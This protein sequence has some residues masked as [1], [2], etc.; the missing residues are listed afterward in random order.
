MNNRFKMNKRDH[1]AILDS[2]ARLLADTEN[3]YLKTKNY[4]WNSSMPTFHTFN[5]MFENQY[6]ELAS[7]FDLIAERIR[8][9]GIAAPVSHIQFNN[10]DALKE[11]SNPPKVQEMIQDLLAD[12]ETII[13]TVRSVF[14]EAINAEDEITKDLMVQR[15]QAHE[16][17]A[18]IFRDYLINK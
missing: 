17:S 15:I 12:Q 8:A 16:K 5:E 6:V 13:K 7:A 3:I 1:K 9:F 4:H 18:S 10:P 2:L 11:T 14:Y